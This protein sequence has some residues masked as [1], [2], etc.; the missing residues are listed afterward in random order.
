[1]LDMIDLQ[2]M[3]NFFDRRIDNEAAAQQRNQGL[4]G[5]FTLKTAVMEPKK[6]FRQQGKQVHNEK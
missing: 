3:V 2:Q 1:M 6:R 4:G 5:K